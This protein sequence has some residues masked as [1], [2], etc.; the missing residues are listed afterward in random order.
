MK[1]KG[2]KII[3][4]LKYNGFEAQFV[5]G[6]VRN[7]QWNKEHNT[8]IKVK[9]F[10]IVTNATP[11]D[12]SRL[13]D[14]VTQR[15]AGFMVSVINI[16]GDEFEVA[17]YR[18]E[19]YTDD[20]TTRPEEVKPAKTLI[21][22]L[23]R[24]D[25]TINTLTEDENGDIKDLMG[26]LDDLKNK[27]IKCV[28][29]P[30][31]RFEEDKLRML[32]AFRFSSQ[33]GATI[34]KETFNAIAECAELLR[35]IPN[36]RIKEEMDKLLKGPA[37]VQTLIAMRSAGFDYVEF[38]NSIEKKQ[39]PFFKSIFVQD[40][41]SFFNAIFPLSGKV[42]SITEIYA[43]LYRDVDPDVAVRE[44][45]EMGLLSTS[46]L[47]KVGI[48][49]RNQEANFIQDR[50]SLLMLVKDIGEQ[51]GR[52]YLEEILKSYSEMYG[53]EF[54]Q[55]RELMTAGPIFKSELPFNGKD[56]IEK[57]KA[58]GLTEPGPWVAKVFA[59]CIAD[60]ILASKFDLDGT[61]ELVSEATMNG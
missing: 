43:L 52:R 7:E 45:E 38:Y 31:K 44:L 46:E 30:I 15:G 36:E 14:N 40:V 34:E 41:K 35:T 56:V 61:L 12:I 37:V 17:Q 6:S 57:G 42:L 23:Q 4:R 2:I 29:E 51:K 55:L 20:S 16:G 27:L 59:K 22:D 21:E 10:D 9:D 53:T 25:F 1:D 47:E 39:V 54:L 26:G 5:G 60:S 32:R 8:N 24:R 3:K 19:T 28:G 33:L 13:F 18:T 58:Y 48:L 49:I 11:E 50:I